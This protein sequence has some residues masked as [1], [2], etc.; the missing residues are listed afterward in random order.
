MLTR[1]GVLGAAAAAGAWLAT[2]PLHAATIDIEETSVAALAA[3]MQ[4]GKVGAVDLVDAYLRRIA[5]ADK[6]LHSVLYTNPDAARDAAALDAERK[7]GKVRGPL[8]GIPILIKG[9]ID[10]ADKMATTAGSLALA[11]R[12]AKKDA[13]VVERLRAAGCVLLG[14][15]NLSEWANFRSTHS[16]SGWSGEGGQA[17]NPYALDRSPSGS[18][19]GSGAAAATSLAAACVGTET[20]GSI[21]S[22]SSCQGLV[23]LKPTV[24]LVSRAGIIPIAH[25]QDT[26]GPMARSVADAAVLLAGM[27]GADPA[28]AATARAPKGADYLAALVAGGLKGARIGVARKKFFGMNPA[29]DR[30]GEDALRILRDAGAVLVDPADVAT[31]GVDDAELEVLLYEFK[32]DLEVYLAAAGTGVRTIADLVAWNDAHATEEM[33]FF[34][35]ELFAQAAKKGPLTDAA[36]RKAVAHCKRQAQTIDAIMAKHRLDAV[37][38]PTGGPAWLIDHVNGD[39]FTGSSTT[40]AAV[41]GYPA[42]TVPAG[43]T[44]GLPLG[45]TFMGKPWTEATLLRLAFGFE[46]IAKARKPPDLRPTVP[47]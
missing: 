36:Y 43:E 26:A 14:K 6:Q 8:H 21:L 31:D 18:S 24:G 15:T 27:V 47:V 13:F 9:N 32:N 22:P 5:A 42:I 44:H 29:A 12:I 10:T 28:D 30:A 33:P 16:S 23:G 39:A 7:A 40:P 45:V 3:A 2:R 11:G 37:V 19:S 20:D 35:Q 17:K 25:S 1:R 41:A 38:C 46:Q 34:G 4:A